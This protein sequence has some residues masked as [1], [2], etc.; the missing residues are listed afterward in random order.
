[1]P[2]EALHGP[3]DNSTDSNAYRYHPT[4]QPSLDSGNHQADRHERLSHRAATGSMSRLA[5]AEAHYQV[6]W[7]EWIGGSAT[8]PDMAI[9]N[10][11]LREP[12][13]VPVVVPEA[14]TLEGRRESSLPFPRQ[15]ATLASAIEAEPVEDGISHAGEILIADVLSVHGADELA[16]AILQAASSSL[17]AS[18]VR[19]IGRVS[20]ED[21]LVRRRIV[22]ACL[23]SSDLQMR[24]AAVQAVE[25]W[26][27]TAC[28][29]LLRRHEEPVDWLADYIRDVI[30]DV[31][32]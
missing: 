28:V 12:V 17:Q 21:A 4:T 31:A 20:V 15:L 6:E 14:R 1:M 25:S 30:A 10:P 27:D 23:R 18:M 5:R 2:L 8:L 3:T 32:G 11:F 24:D 7:I 29:D 9:T 22:D 26:E 19:L 16:T 13:A